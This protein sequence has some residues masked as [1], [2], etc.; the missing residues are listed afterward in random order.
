MNKETVLDRAEASVATVAS[1]LSELDSLI[2]DAQ[3]LS[4]AI[5]AL[6]NDEADLLA[7]DRPE[8][9]KHKALLSLRASLDIKQANLDKLNKEISAVKS[10]VRI[11]GNKANLFLG[12]LFDALVVAR[13]ALVSEQLKALFVPQAQLELQRFLPYSAAVQEIEPGIERLQW[14]PVTQIE[15]NVATARK[16]RATFDKLA[17]LVEADENISIIVSE[18]W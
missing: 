16:V 13:R 18:S 1:K 6:E 11:L 10:D 14:F 15:N 12:A 4:E 17:E 3:N 9:Q 8:A 7:S 5:E 2:N